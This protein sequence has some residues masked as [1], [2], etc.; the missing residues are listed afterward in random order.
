MN[1]VLDLVD[2]WAAAEQSNDPAQIDALLA[3]EFVG[4]GAAG[5]VLT[6]EQ[7]L[8][9]RRAQLHDRMRRRRAALWESRL[10]RSLL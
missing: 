3:P 2:R 9:A 4:V 7:W 10:G 6:R 1:D 5:F 8:S